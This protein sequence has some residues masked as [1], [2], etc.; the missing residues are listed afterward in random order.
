MTPIEAIQ[1]ATIVPARVMRI[2]KESGTV[3][4]GKRAD[5]VILAGNPLENI[6]NIR[7]ARLV[8]AGGALYDCARLWAA[9]GYR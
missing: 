5:L 1:A 8:V 7:T 4:V 6:S 3:E 2:D 9:A